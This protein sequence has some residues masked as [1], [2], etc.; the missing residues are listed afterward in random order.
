VSEALRF[1]ALSELLGLAA[2]PMTALVLGRLPGA[3]LAFAKPL[4]LLAAAYPLWLLV[5]FHLVPYGSVSAWA[6]VGLLVVGGLALRRRRPR[7]FSLAGGLE[8]RLLVAAEVTFAVAFLGAALLNAYSPE[9]RGTEKPMDM[10]FLNAVN[11]SSSFP[12]HDPWLAGE[13]LNYYWL[14]HYLMAFGI[15]LTG[16]E[17]SVGYNLSLALLFALSAV[18]AFGLASALTAAA[19]GRRPVLAGLLAAGFVC[20]AG[21]LEGA[22]KLIVDGGPLAS[23]DWFGASRVVPDAITEFPAFSFV[24]GDLHAHVLAI[25]FTLLALAFGL[26]VAMAG[27]RWADVLPAGIAVGV[28]YA[29]NA[30]SY[31]VVA[32]LV[33]LACLM[34]LRE[35][36]SSMSRAAGWS[37]GML[38]VSVL[39]VLP[40]WFT[41]EPS[42]GGF[43]LVSERRSPLLFARDQALILGVFG[44]ILLAAGAQRRRDAWVC[45]AAVERFFWLLAV[46]GVACVALAEIV[47]V[48]DGFD[49][50]DLYRMNTVFKLSYEAW[51]LLAVAAACALTLARGRLPLA[52]WVPATLLLVGLTAIYPVAGSYAR[53]AAFSNGPRLDGM[54]WLAPGDVAAITWLRQNS[55]PDAVVLEAV[56]PDYSE[57]GY[58][59]ISTFSGRAAV[60]G[61]A[62]HELQWGHDAGARRDDVAR[63]YRGTDPNAVRALLRRYGVTHVIVG[64]LERADHGESGFAGFDELG[65]RVFERDGTI[66]WRLYA[67]V[68]RRM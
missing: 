12:P 44:L 37:V 26:Q 14:G 53:K 19:N 16:V 36:G 64:P 5:S 40:F 32:G 3:G 42:T 15:R 29:I 13:D 6:G 2:L 9:V 1:L 20:V 47:Y 27:P 35:P 8:G 33:V 68:S 52:V 22:R 43:G 25:P 4:G 59:R 49:G 21:N 31:P 10:A 28:L 57:L 23:Y 51:I 54:R 67:A 58:T 62:G 63:M 41:F 48:R 39:A 55:D 61:W 38:A 60:L 46:G 65:R 66:V 30:W 24:L 56:G 45:R 18:A 7:R 50:S 34:S 11:A 17:P